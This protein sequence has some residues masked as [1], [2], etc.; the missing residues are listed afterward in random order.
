M[1][2]ISAKLKEVVSVNNIHVYA[3]E[4][5]SEECVRSS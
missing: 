5:P 1:I 3:T 2:E 4:L